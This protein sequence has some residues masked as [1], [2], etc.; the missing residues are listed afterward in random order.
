MIK[1]SINVLNNL[2]I[3][4]DVVLPYLLV[5]GEKYLE[6]ME[7]IGNRSV[8]FSYRCAILQYYIVAYTDTFSHNIH[9]YVI[10]MYEGKRKIGAWH[11]VLFIQYRLRFFVFANLSSTEFE[12]VLFKFFCLL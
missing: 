10:I 4:S 5:R 11:P 12:Y 1:L 3:M 6:C 2:K 8:L 9:S 7:L